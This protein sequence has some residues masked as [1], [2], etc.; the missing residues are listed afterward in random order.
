M[1][2][3]AILAGSIIGKL[4]D[5]LAW[6]MIGVIVLL[7]ACRCPWWATLTAVVA[8]TVAN[9]AI[10]HPWLIQSGLTLDPAR[11]ARIFFALLIIGIAA[12]GIG[13]LIARF[14]SEPSSAVE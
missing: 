12:H 9:F 6:A 5:P 2:I 1:T 7:A 8:A 10:I 3:L 14:S 11:Q 13:R 4:Y